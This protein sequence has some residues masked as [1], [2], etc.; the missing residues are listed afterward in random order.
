MS[1]QRPVITPKRLQLRGAFHQAHYHVCLPG[2][3]V[4]TNS[5]MLLKPKLLLNNMLKSAS[6]LYRYLLTVI[7][8]YAKCYKYLLSIFYDLFTIKVINNDIRGYYM[9]VFLIL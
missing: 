4:H 7:I 9:G 3:F 1:R 6:I 8:K 2:P 5:Q